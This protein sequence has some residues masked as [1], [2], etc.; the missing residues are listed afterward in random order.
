MRALIKNTFVRVN[1]GESKSHC[2]EEMLFQA[3]S[4]GV[5]GKMKIVEEPV[6]EIEN[7]EILIAAKEI[8]ELTA[9]GV[10]CC[11]IIFQQH[12][13]TIEGRRQGTKIP[14]NFKPVSLAL[15]LVFF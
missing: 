1:G 10:E 11:Q 7:G 13:L 9:I 2:G 8:S 14:F 6:M 5:K 4:L 15:G 12:P 3:Q